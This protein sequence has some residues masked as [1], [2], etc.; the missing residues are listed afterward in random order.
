MKAYGTYVKLQEEF[1]PKT[2]LLDRY[3]VVKRIPA[4]NPE[5]VAGG[6]YQPGGGG[7]V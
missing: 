1:G 2:F 4:L 6:I 7:G 3:E 5:M